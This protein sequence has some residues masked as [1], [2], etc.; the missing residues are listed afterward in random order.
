M[1]RGSQQFHTHVS[2]LVSTYLAGTWLL[3]LL[4]AFHFSLL[5]PGTDSRY[6]PHS[7]AFVNAA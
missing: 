3:R 1:E 2:P 5:L 6:D 4:A 7:R